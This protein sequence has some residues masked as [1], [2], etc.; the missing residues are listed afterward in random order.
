MKAWQSLV[1][2]C[3][4]GAVVLVDRPEYHDVDLGRPGSVLHEKESIKPVDKVVD[5]VVENAA[6]PVYPPSPIV[7]R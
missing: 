1:I 3:C 4:F 6:K 7:W 2:I 5:N